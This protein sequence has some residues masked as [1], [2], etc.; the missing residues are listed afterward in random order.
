MSAIYEYLGASP[1]EIPWGPGR[2]VA[3]Y[4]DG[5]EWAGFCFA[6]YSLVCFFCRSALMAGDFFMR[7]AALL[8]QRVRDA[9]PT[10]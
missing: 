7:L 9:A 1:D 8:V 3:A 5:V 4:R 6:M 2:E 10:S